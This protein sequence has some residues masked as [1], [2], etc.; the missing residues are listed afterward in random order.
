MLKLFL[1]SRYTITV[2]IEYHDRMS[3]MWSEEGLR[4]RA[5]AEAWSLSEIEAG[6]CPACGR[7]IDISYD[8]VAVT[9]IGKYCVCGTCGY[10]TKLNEKNKKKK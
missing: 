2:A 4:R 10:T 3:I 5:E 7:K 6:R 9:G 8:K 1:F